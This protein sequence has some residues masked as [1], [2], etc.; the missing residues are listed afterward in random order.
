MF[1]ARSFFVFISFWP[2]WLFV[3]AHRLSVAALRLSLVAASRGYSPVAVLRLPLQWLLKL[4]SRGLQSLEQRLSC[5][6]GQV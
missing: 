3:T 1:E 5:C 2:H 6:S 4:S